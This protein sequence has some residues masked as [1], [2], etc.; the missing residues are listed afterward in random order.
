[1]KTMIIKVMHLTKAVNVVTLKLEKKF[2]P[3]WDSNPLL[4]QY[5]CSVLAT[6]LSSQLGV[7]NVP[8]DG[9]ESK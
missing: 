4:L 8:T 3:E 9:K 2:K 6:N 5:W 1:M 7:C